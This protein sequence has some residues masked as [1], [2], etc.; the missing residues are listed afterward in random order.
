[1]SKPDAWKVQSGRY[2]HYCDTRTDAETS[3]HNTDPPATITP[4]YAI[5]PEVREALRSATGSLEEKRIA[6]GMF[7]SMPEMVG[8]AE[9]ER[10]AI[11]RHIAALERLLDE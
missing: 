2:Y 5:T 9:R 7:R 1:M 8:E 11:D 6:I 4:L 3:G 10:A